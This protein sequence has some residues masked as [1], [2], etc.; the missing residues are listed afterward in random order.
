MFTIDILGNK[1]PLEL[2]L[3]TPQGNPILCLSSGVDDTT[4][5]LSVTLNQKYELTFS[6]KSVAEIDG[7]L[8]KSPG[9]DLL[10]DGSYLALEKIGLFKM[11]PPTINSDG[12]IETKEITAQSCDCELEEKSLNV[13]INMGET[14]SEEFLVTYGDDESELVLNEYTGIPYDYIVLYN[15]F[16]QQLQRFQIDYDSGFYGTP[17]KDITVTDKEKISKLNDIATL[18]PRLKSRLSRSVDENGNDLLTEKVY[19]SYEYNDDQKSTISSISLSSDFQIRIKELISFYERNR[20]KIS[21]L[22]IALKKME[23]NWTVGEVYG[24]LEGDYTLCNRRTSFEINESIYSFLTQTLAQSIECVVYFDIKQRKVNVIPA[25]KIGNNTGIV[26]SYETLVNS[27]N[28]TYDESNLATRLYVTGSDGLSI[29]DVNIG[30]EYIEDLTYKISAR[31]DF[32]NRIYVSDELAD[33]YIAYRNFREEQRLLWVDC[34]KKY[35]ENLDK[36]SEIMN[37]VPDEDLKDDWGKYSLDLLNESLNSYKNSL[38]TLKTLYREDY[39]SV[40]INT[41]GSI[42]EEYIK[43]TEY[44]CDYVAYQNII[45]QI[46]AAIETFPNYSDTSKWSEENKNK[47]E[48]AINYW[49][50]Q[51]G[52]FGIN[53]LKTKISTYKNN[54]VIQIKNKTVCPVDSGSDSYEIKTWNQMTDLER[55][56]YGSVQ[57]KYEESYELYKKYY[58]NWVDATD[59]LNKVLIPQLNELN[60]KQEEINK[61]RNEIKDKVSYEN[62]FTEN[63][64]KQLCLLY[65]DAEYSNENI[66]ITSIDDSVSMLDKQEELLQDSKERLEI[67]S[68]PQLIFSAEINNLLSIPEF[69]PLVNDFQLGN[70]IY[71]ELRDNTYVQVRLSQYQFNPF[72]PYTN[73][74]SVG[75]SNYIISKSKRYDTTYL[76]N[77]SIA[78]GISNYSTG[79]GGSSGNLLDNKYLSDTILAKLLNTE[80]FGAKVKDVVL[81]TM[82]LNIISAKKS[83]FGE[84]FADEFNIANGGLVYKDGKL[85]V[86]GIITW[87]NEGGAPSESSGELEELKKSLGYDPTTQIDGKSIISPTIK[88]GY[89]LIGNKE[90][91]TYAEI[92]SVGNFKAVNAELI[93]NITATKITAQDSI[94]LFYNPDNFVLGG[95]NAVPNEST[96]IASRSWSG[97]D[98]T[99]LIGPSLIYGS[100]ES[101]PQWE[102][103]CGIEICSGGEYGS[104]ITFKANNVSFSGAISSPNSN[105]LFNEISANNIVKTDGTSVS[106]SNHKHTGLSCGN[107]SNT[108]YKDTNIFISYYNSATNQSSFRPTSEFLSNSKIGTSLGSPS[109]KW[110]NIYA[111]TSTISTSDARLKENVKEFDERFEAMFMELKPCLYT[112]K[113]GSNQN[114]HDRTHGGYIAQE[115]EQSMN[116]NGISAIDYAFLC[117]DDV[118]TFENENGEQNN[119]FSS[120]GVNDYLYSLRYEEMTPLNTHMIQKAFREIEYLKNENM[121]LKSRIEQLEKGCDY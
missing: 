100:E 46:E 15:T 21:L 59:Y 107:M 18:I 43:N 31:D 75:F 117:K 113:N 57:S 38:L 25:D 50:T 91:G 1:E 77:L 99:L 40:G 72:N 13:K 86:N 23:G 80:T 109:L 93:G 3:S 51:W 45:V 24:L 62:Y 116:N 7:K 92:T 104:T 97:D 29:S 84:L 36:I 64:R 47:Y 69:E 9:Y 111:D 74:L 76:L 73:D 52:L 112:F 53:E 32:G 11:F 71:V 114:L 95:G 120:F 5:N 119:P 65:K 121:K 68:R 60:K 22:D 35:N 105:V 14:D 19:M 48:D 58:D 70:Y 89:L 102:C 30:Q 108:D 17:N 41:D 56:E 4:S 26:L 88:G 37:R 67:Y 61:I 110:G 8:V 54:M 28:I 90:N 39:G 103:N 118:N 78:D 96:I 94:S 10:V 81:D 63:E 33:K 12:L 55:T 34:T 42:N 87:Q 27:L 101:N 16:P 49:Q 44:Y 82:E 2:Y 85:Y 83:I 106:W 66:L 98:K 115:V 79:N 6:Y 20:S